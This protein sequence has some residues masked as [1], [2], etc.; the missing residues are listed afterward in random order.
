MKVSSKYNAVEFC[1]SELSKVSE[2]YKNMIVIFFY[3]VT[4][5]VLFSSIAHCVMYRACY[6]T[7]E[8]EPMLVVSRLYLN[9]DIYFRVKSFLC[10]TS[11]I[12]MRIQCNSIRSSKFI[13]VQ[14]LVRT[15]KLV[16]R[17]P[18]QRLCK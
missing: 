8:T 14:K 4:F 12:D 13:L 2:H 15:A 6:V 7:I 5:H 11:V 3:I 17:C 16:S 10:A 9:E 18:S 1:V